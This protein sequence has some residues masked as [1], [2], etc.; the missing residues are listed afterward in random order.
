MEYEREQAKT[1]RARLNESP[2]SI[3]V[4]AGPRQVGKTT[5]VRQVIRDWQSPLVAVDRPE[6]SSG[7]S[8]STLQFPSGSTHFVGAQPTAE[9]LIEKWNQARVEARRRADDKPYVLALD[10]IQKIS[11]WSEI[12]KGLWDEDRGLGINLHVV[13][14]G[15]SPWLM[16]KGLTESLAGRF[17]MI[18][19]THWAYYEMQ[20]AF[21][22]SVEEFIYFGGY[23]GS[24]RYINDEPRWRS[25]IRESLIYPCVEKDILEMTRVDKPI[26]LRNLFELGCLYSG[27][28]VAYSKLLCQLQ[29]K[30]NT[31]TLATYLSLLS[32]A[33]M[34]TGLEKYSG[35]KIQAKKSHQN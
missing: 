7:I 15:S 20:D 21:D 22:F 11:N 29:E 5:M 35:S 24:A 34:L 31:T 26:L 23:P 18:R 9:W 12:V 8:S 33:G 27:R 6:T 4:V 2:T 17:E 16:G 32:Q 25:Y 1:L 13:L 14:L 28:I 19:M 30:G 3:I 10:E